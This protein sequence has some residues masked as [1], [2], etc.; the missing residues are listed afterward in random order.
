MADIDSNFIVI[1]SSGLSWEL[2]IIGSGN[3]SAPYGW[4]PIAWTTDNL[5][6]R[7]G[8]AST[9][10]TFIITTKLHEPCFIVKNIFPGMGID[11]DKTFVRP[12]YL[13]GENIYTVKMT[14]LY[15]TGVISFL[16]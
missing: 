15:R 8:Y 9:G 10:L 5:V 1:C 7:K 6:V 12:F 3:G 4:K 16:H 14:S 13:Y 11:K 2:Y